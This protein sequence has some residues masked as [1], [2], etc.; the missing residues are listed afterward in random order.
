MEMH[1][2]SSNY[3]TMTLREILK[4]DTSAE[5]QAMLSASHCIKP[6]QSDATAA[7]TITDESGNAHLTEFEKDNT[8]ENDVKL[9]EGTN[10]KEDKTLELDKADT[11][12]L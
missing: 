9:H 10:A 3:A 11:A 6:I 1:L 8:G 12:K 4:K 5:T 2:K 7:E